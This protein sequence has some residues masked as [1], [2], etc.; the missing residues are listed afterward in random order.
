LPRRSILSGHVDVHLVAATLD[1]LFTGQ[2]RIFGRRHPAWIKSHLR[3]DLP[4]IQ[5]VR[6]DH[7]RVVRL[8]DPDR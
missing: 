5:L 3:I 6:L 7:L 2:C 8:A 4:H 1:P